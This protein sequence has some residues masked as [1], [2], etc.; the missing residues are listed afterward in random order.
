[1][2][3]L[4][5]VCV[6]LG[7]AIF[8]LFL[9]SRRLTYQEQPQ[10]TSPKQL[11]TAKSEIESLEFEKSILSHSITSAYEFA[12]GNGRS[13]ERDHL[14]TKYK[15][16][17]DNINKRID[18]LQLSV[19]FTELSEARNKLVSLIEAKITSLD[20]R[21]SEMSQKYGLSMDHS[22]EERQRDSIPQYQEKKPFSKPIEARDP[23][24]EFTENKSEDTNVKDV[25][26]EILQALNRLENVDID[27]E[28]LSQ[29]SQLEPKTSTEGDRVTS[30]PLKTI[31]D[32]K[33]DNNITMDIRRVSRDAVSSIVRSNPS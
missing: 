6:A 13:Q 12:H 22:A 25:Q 26:Q 5:I 32:N 17:L 19:E 10:N 24:A 11:E 14:V 33:N 15:S 20:G 18:E 7:G 29:S 27:Y 2:E 3:I 16:Q 4:V 1:V 21:L 23:M 9:L 28:L 8:T 30:Y 31:Q